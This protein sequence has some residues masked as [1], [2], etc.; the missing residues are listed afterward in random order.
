MLNELSFV[1]VFIFLSK[2]VC[3]FSFFFFVE[4]IVFESSVRELAQATDK[5]VFKVL[6]EMI[7]LSQ[8]HCISQNLGYFVSNGLISVKEGK[9]LPE[10]INKLCASVAKVSLSICDAFAIPQRLMPPIAMDWVEYNKW[11]NEGE[12]MLQHPLQP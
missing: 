12:F 4:Q 11:D 5:S 1:F 10:R 8:F 9:A 3:C 6:R 2:N 7:L